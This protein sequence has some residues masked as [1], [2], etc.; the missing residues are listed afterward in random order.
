MSI[1]CLKTREPNLF[2]ETNRLTDW[3]INDTQIVILHQLIMAEMVEYASD[4]LSCVTLQEAPLHAENTFCK[5][6]QLG[7]S[8]S[9]CWWHLQHH[10]ILFDPKS[11]IVWDIQHSFMD[12]ECCCGVKLFIDARCS[13]WTVITLVLIPLW[14]ISRSLHMLIYFSISCLLERSCLLESRCLL[15][16]S[17]HDCHTIAGV[18][19]SHTLP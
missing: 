2:L 5:Q 4:M 16:S 15:E 8:K 14:F 11:T 10:S 13:H 6:L 3:M 17:C 12:W 9:S 18:W 19:N 7:W 1:F